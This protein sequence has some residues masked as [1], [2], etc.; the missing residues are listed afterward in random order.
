M[1]APKQS[2]RPSP[3]LAPADLVALVLEAA[4]AAPGL[5][6]ADLKKALPRPH[7]GH[8]AAAILVL[9]DLA[10]TGQLFR[11][12]KGKVERFFA[13]DP[14]ATLDREVPSLLARSGPLALTALKKAVGA[15]LKGHREL[16]P[17]WTKSALVR[18]IVFWHE[19][20]PGSRGKRLGHTPDVRRALVKTFAALKTAVSA[21]EGAGVSRT[22]VLEVLRDE[23]GL[24]HAEDGTSLLATLE[25]VASMHRPGTLLLVADVRARSSLPKERF[26]AAA[27]AL[28]RERKLVLHHHDHP[29]ALSEGERDT[30]VHGGQGTYY[31]GIARRSPT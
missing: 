26:D 20:S 4:R 22:R 16:L 17:E 3:P 21:L 2:T 25:A 8:H 10:S 15:Q 30:L 9:R 14:V 28:A 31:V 13:V 27:L 24:A 1:S 12:A 11:F 23:L 18:G 29:A 6:P 19:P 5:R 7:Q